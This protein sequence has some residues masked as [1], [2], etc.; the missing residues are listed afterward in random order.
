V[1]GDGLQVQQA[2][3]SEDVGRGAERSCTAPAGYS[4]LNVAQF[5]MA[6]A[7]AS[8]WQHH[9][10]HSPQVWAELDGVGS[11]FWSGE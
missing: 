4:R 7:A 6:G 1:H 3:L 8:E 5:G 9:W 2:R 11:L 10:L